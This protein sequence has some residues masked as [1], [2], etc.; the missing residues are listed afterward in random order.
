MLDVPGKPCLR[1]AVKA[2]LT[3]FKI[4]TKNRGNRTK[5]NKTA[6]PNSN[7]KGFWAVFRVIPPHAA[8]TH[9]AHSGYGACITYNKSHATRCHHESAITRE[10]WRTTDGLHVCPVRDVYYSSCS[11]LSSARS[12]GVVLVVGLSGLFQVRLRT[13]GC[14]AVLVTGL[15]RMSST[16][17]FNR[18]DGA[19]RRPIK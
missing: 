15:N 16:A 4:E 13:A 2:F 18:P 17:F 1:P 5:Q 3:H 6:V 12:V 11:I 9:T 8:P 19:T 7:Q 14:A 10:G